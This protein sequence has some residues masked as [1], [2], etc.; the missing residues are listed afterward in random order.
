LLLDEAPFPKVE[1]FKSSPSCRIPA[2]DESAE[3]VY[4]SH[5]FEHLDDLTVFRL[6]AETR[7]VLSERGSLL[8]KIPNFRLFKRNFA[9]NDHSLLEYC[10]T[11]KVQHTWAR[12]GVA[13]SP[14]M[15]TA[16]MFCGY[17]NREYGD[18]FSKQISITS[19][20]YHGPPMLP[21]AQVSEIIQSLSVRE[22]SDLFNRAALSD[23]EFKQFNHQNAWDEQDFIQVVEESGF[24]CLSTSL[25]EI[26]SLQ[27]EVPDL[28]SM[29]E[30]SSYYLFRHDLQSR[31]GRFGTE[32]LQT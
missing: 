22:I 23:P 21:E 14:A 15:Q 26:K 31:R 16:M 27:T 25:E 8:I 30:I 9:H 20:A 17:W 13:S 19:G 29:S 32:R 12:F 18:H 3:L 6:L 4:S 7:R 2:E 11:H 28:L 5:H 10:G 24:K 1:Y